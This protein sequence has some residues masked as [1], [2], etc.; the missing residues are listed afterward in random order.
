MYVL[1]EQGFLFVC[2]LIAA[3]YYRGLLFLLEQTAFSQIKK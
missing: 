2:F 1:T 3:T